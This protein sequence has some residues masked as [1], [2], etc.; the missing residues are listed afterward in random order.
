MSGP[1]RTSRVRSTP[2]TNP[3]CWGDDSDG[4]VSG[5]PSTGSWQDVECG[6]NFCCGL[7]FDGSI[8]CWGDNLHG[9]LNAPADDNHRDLAVGYQQACAV[10]ANREPVCWGRD[11]ATPQAS[12]LIDFTDTPQLYMDTIAVGHT[13]ASAAYMTISSSARESVQMEKSVTHPV[14]FDSTQMRTLN[15]ELTAS[16]RHGPDPRDRVSA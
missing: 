2:T 11:V 10:N 16:F 5:H 9:Q 13:F 14:A 15:G 4:Q 7:E 3:S 6:A 1:A 12:A 8:E